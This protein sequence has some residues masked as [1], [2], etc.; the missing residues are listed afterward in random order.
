MRE[1]ALFQAA[2]AFQAYRR[3]GGT[4]NGVLPDFLMGAQAAALRLP[5]LTR[6][7]GRYTTSFPD[8]VPI[9]PSR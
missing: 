7:R 9:A 8:V 6:D 3:R 2:R 5:L 4:R 1:D